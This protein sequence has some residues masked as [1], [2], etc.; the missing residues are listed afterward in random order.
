MSDHEDEFEDAVEGPLSP[1]EQEEREMKSLEE[2]RANCFQKHGQKEESEEDVLK[3]AQKAQEAVVEDDGHDRSLEEASKAK[4][5]GNEFFRDKKYLEAAEMYSKAIY[6]CPLG[7]EHKEQM[8]V[9]Y[10][11]RSACYASIG[12]NE[13][14]ISDCTTALELNSNYL[15]VLMRRCQTYESLERYD[16]A[17]ADVKTLIEFDSDYPK[18]RQTLA[19]LERLHAEKMEKMKDEALGKL[20]E[21][22]NTVLGKFGMSLDNF[23][24]QQ[25]PNTGSWSINMKS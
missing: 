3:E 17:I 19:R 25:D 24:M 10:G 23:N 9:F 13:L 12:D 14:A 1:Q 5:S 11:N 16:D 2:T 7:D 18:A 8:A 21:L 4:A 15:K 22:G 20:K 6:Y